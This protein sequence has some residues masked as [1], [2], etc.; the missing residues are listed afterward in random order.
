MVSVWAT[1]SH[2]H[3]PPIITQVGGSHASILPVTMVVPD[4]SGNQTSARL[5]THLQK[6]EVVWLTLIQV[7]HFS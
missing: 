5:D 4:P 6:D 7:D 1:C 3:D 2:L